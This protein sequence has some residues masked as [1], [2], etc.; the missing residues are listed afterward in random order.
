MSGL[1]DEKLTK[2]QNQHKNRV[3]YSSATEITT[4]FFNIFQVIC[5]NFNVF[6]YV[7]QRERSVSGLRKQMRGLGVDM[8][9]DEEVSHMFA[10][11]IFYWFI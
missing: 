7:K 10:V 6:F 9:S 8:E 11:I 2:Y 4:H 3:D 5:H 1:S